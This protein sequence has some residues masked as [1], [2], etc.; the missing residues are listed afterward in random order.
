MNV[1]EAHGKLS[2][3]FMRGVRE[4]GGWPGESDDE[5]ND[6]SRAVV[7]AMRAEHGQAWLGKINLYDADRV[8]NGGG[9]PEQ[10]LWKWDGS[11]VHNFEA[12]FVA[13]CF[14]A[15]LVRLIVERDAA[16]YTGTREDCARIEAITDRINAIG[17]VNLFWT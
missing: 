1:Q 9:R 12:C 16:P 11:L 8:K 13:P 5:I 6:A 17:G 14:D 4:C 15:E 10:V 2:R 3:E 7:E